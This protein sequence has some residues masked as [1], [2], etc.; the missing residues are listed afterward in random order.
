MCVNAPTK[1]FCVGTY[2]ERFNVS[3]RKQNKTKQN[4]TEKLLFKRDDAI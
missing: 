4:K 2:V 1:A 3:K